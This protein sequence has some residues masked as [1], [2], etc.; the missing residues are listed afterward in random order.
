MPANLTANVIAYYPFSSGSL[1]DFSGNGIHLSNNTTAKPA[2]D[3]NGNPECAFEFDN[4][5]NKVDSLVATKT[6]NL[7]S[8]SEFS[9]SLWYQPLDT[10]V[11]KHHPKVEYMVRYGMWYVML[12]D[13]RKA[14]FDLWNNNSS[15]YSIWDNNTYP[16]GTP[17]ICE[18]EQ[19]LRTGSWHHLV[20]TFD[21][22]NNVAKIYRNSVLQEQDGSVPFSTFATAPN[23]TSLLIGSSFTGRM[24]DI[25]IFNKVLNAIEIN[26][27]YHTA[28][29]C[30]T[31]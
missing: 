22:A 24:D 14:S 20:V 4:F 25:A 21:K 10:F 28:P 2:P 30:S 11:Q 23:I 31:M 12:F 19:K 1:N 3:R 15:G 7:N 18:Q 26:I 9:I 5:P 6:S 16:L 27:L 13:C 17:D 8:L 29:C